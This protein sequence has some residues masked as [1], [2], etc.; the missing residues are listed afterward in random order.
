M[1]RGLSL[2]KQGFDL[3]KGVFYRI[4]VRGVGGQEAQFAPLGL[5]QL[6]HLSVGMDT[7]VVK[8]DDLPWKQRGTEHV[9]D[10]SY[11]LDISYEDSSI[12]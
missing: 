12:D 9:L 2:F 3:G 1:R 11:K 6:A 8:D 5:D 10:I 4:K 7:V